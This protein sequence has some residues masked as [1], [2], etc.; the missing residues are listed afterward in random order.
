VTQSEQLREPNLIR[1]PHVEK[2]VLNWPLT[3]LSLY[4]HSFLCSLS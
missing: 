2:A 3:C 4:P 1:D